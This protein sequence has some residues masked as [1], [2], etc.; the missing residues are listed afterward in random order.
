MDNMKNSPIDKKY[1][2]WRIQILIGMYAGYTTYYLTRKS[3]T[4]V[5]PYL[6]AENI[7]D[8]PTLGLMGTVFY[9]I[10]G[11]SKFV[12]GII[13]DKSNPRYFM[14]IGLILT[15]IVNIAFGLSTSAPLFIA[16]WAVNAYFQGWGWAPCSKLLTFWYSKSERGT[17]WSIQSSSHNV[18][19]ALIPIIVGTAATFLGWRFGMITP[20][21]VAILMGVLVILVLRDKP[22]TM[23]LPSVGEWRND[24][25][26]LIH[27]K[28]S[29]PQDTK[30]ILINYVFKNKIIWLLSASYIF[31]YIIRTAIND[32][33]NVYITEEYGYDLITSNLVVT[34]FEIGGFLGTLF[35]GWGSD[36]FFKGR[37]LPVNIIFTVGVVCVVLA[38]YSLH[39]DSYIYLSILLFLSGFFIFGPQLLITIMAAEMS[40]KDAAG[41]TVGFVSLFGYIGAALSGYPVA[42]V[43]EKYHWNGYFL[44][45]M[46]S[47]IIAL[48][49]ILP[50]LYTK[51][52]NEI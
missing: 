9:L 47:G 21:M 3:L 2:R 14:G 10:Y 49:T 15:G 28:E 16:L 31:V 8:K 24:E 36:F 40:H 44:V 18:G 37:R 17:W 12:S 51:Y 42:L 25:L 41:A 27:E 23:G 38:L 32:W 6:L 26:E 29:T 43:I 48:V 33:S 11:I 19:G 4:F 1:K 7:L 5:S 22:S 45:L 46:I 13:S 50:I 52:R 20:G 35:A 34:F 30:T 39:I